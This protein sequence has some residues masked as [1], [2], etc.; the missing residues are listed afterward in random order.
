VSIAFTE[1]T[2][3]S[4][5]VSWLHFAPLTGKQSVTYFPVMRIPERKAIS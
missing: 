4:K 1:H 2:I 5:T 3:F